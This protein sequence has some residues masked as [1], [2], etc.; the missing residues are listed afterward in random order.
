VQWA[1]R[2][3]DHVVAGGDGAKR[4]GDFELLAG[5]F[6]AVGSEAGLA[7]EPEPLA[8]ASPLDQRRAL[9]V[10]VIDVKKKVA[11]GGKLRR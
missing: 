11:P 1:N 6:S 5:L 2:T 3:L 9:P 7:T 8:V 10:G 4:L